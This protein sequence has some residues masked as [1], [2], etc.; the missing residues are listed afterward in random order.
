ML[1][2]ALGGGAN[3]ALQVEWVK[4]YAPQESRYY[5][6]S[7][8]TNEVT[9]IAPEGYEA[10]PS[11]VAARF[12]M[13][14][15]LRATLCI[16]GAWRS[17]KARETARAAKAHAA[18]L[19]EGGARVFRGWV[20][21]W[22]A[23]AK[24]EYYFQ[25][26][27][28]HMQWGVP[29][30]LVIPKWVK[31]FDPTTQWHYFVN[32]DTGEQSSEVPADYHSP[33]GPHAKL[34]SMMITNPEL[35]SA[36]AIQRAFRSRQ[37]RRVAYATQLHRRHVEQAETKT[38]TIPKDGALGFHLTEPDDDDCGGA[39]ICAPL[40][41]LGAAPLQ[42]PAQVGNIIASGQAEA[43]G[44]QRGDLLSAVAGV[45]VAGSTIK[46]ALNRLRRANRPVE[47]CVRR[48]FVPDPQYPRQKFPRVPSVHMGWMQV[49]FEGRALRD[50][51][52]LVEGGYA[53]LDDHRA[54]GI[55]SARGGAQ[56]GSTVPAAQPNA[57]GGVPPRTG[58]VRRGAARPGVAHGARA[59]AHRGR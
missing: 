18:G 6:Y 31:I 43:A 35:R 33:R 40:P 46:A 53:D 45:N 5:Y 25:V 28:G 48:R 50:G 32:N 21:V 7:N 36:M 22:D 4:C 34:M 26:S 19:L 52:V 47:L 51:P 9:W 44:F 29:N 3:A 24:A 20:T 54:A 56:A 17:K 14:P 30:E 59:P 37:T 10:P 57:Q 55:C 38:F 11:G 12:L 58:R 41:P 23:Y 27:T 42:Y 39:G 2:V 13:S 1:P 8:F 16:Q 15:L 49:E